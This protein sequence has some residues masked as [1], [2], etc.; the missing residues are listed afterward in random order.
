[1]ETWVALCTVLLWV[2][3]A[4][5]SPYFLTTGNI[6]NI[7]RQVSVDA[8]IAYGELFT[9]I[10]AGIDLSVGSVAGLTGIVFAL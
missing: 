3:L 7:M 2:G 1:M 10:T 5:A 4:V 8:I 9:I 6:F